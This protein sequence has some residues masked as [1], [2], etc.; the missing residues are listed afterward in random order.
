M[1]KPM[2]FFPAG[3]PAGVLLLAAALN[4]AEQGASSSF[5]RLLPLPVPRVVA[6][7]EAY[8][9]GS[10]EAPR[11][12]DGNLRTEF[13]SKGKG[14]NTFVEFDFGQ[15]VSVAGLRHVDRNDPATVASS[16]LEF[17]DAAGNVLATVPVVH[18]N[19]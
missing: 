8:P 10:F 15:P 11:L 14:T 16:E 5:V 1:Q 3:F 18:V 17:L 7:A 12:V 2:L 6:A 4:A 9:G 19:Q 13:S